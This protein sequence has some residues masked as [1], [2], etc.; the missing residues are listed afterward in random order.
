MLGRGYSERRSEHHHRRAAAGSFI[1]PR[2]ARR[3][4]D[5]SSR[6]SECDLRRSCHS[7]Y[8]VARLKDGVSVETAL[9]NVKSIA[10]QLEKQYPDSNRGQGAAVMRP[11]RSDCWK[12]SS[13]TAGAAGRRGAAVADRQRER[14]ESA[15]GPF[16]EP[17]A[18]DRGAHARS[19]RRRARLIS[20][21]VTE[22]LV[23]V[24]AGS[25]LGLASAHWAMQLL[26]GLIPT[27]MLAGMPYL[28]G[29]GLNVRV[30][31]FAGA[32]SLLAAVLFSITPTL[33]LSLPE[34]RAGPGRWQPRFRGKY[35]RRLGSKLVVLELATA[36]VLLGGRRTA[37]Q[38]SLPLA[39]CKHRIA[40]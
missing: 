35:W 36:M 30:L 15:A 18:R 27:D 24:A 38:E 8:G 12:Y 26:T 32:I 1:S 11:D 13:D 19:V 9:A 4:L 7:L 10:Q 17:P 40:A 16:R 28:H 23:L 2:R 37:R 29:L 34:M 3:V 20:Q 14:C 31:A 5:D 39:A 22:G 25:V 6:P 33:R 21:F